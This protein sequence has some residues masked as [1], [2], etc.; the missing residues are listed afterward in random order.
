MDDLVI[1]HHNGINVLRDDLLLG[2]SKTRYLEHIL[3]KN[4]KGY[5]YATNVYGGFQIALSG[6]GL[7]NKKPVHIFCSHRAKTH[8]NTKVCYD[9]K[10][11]VHELKNKHGK[12]SGIY[13]S[14]VTQKAEQFAEQ[15]GLQLVNFGGNYPAVI[16]NIAFTMR[17]IITKL[18]KEPDQIWCAVGSGTLL[19]G[20]LKGTKKANVFGVVVGKS[21]EM[22]HERLTLLPY[23]KPFS[24]ESRFPV[25]F[26]ST[27]NYDAKAFEYC[28]NFGTGDKFFWNVY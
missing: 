6:Y 5:V 3:N 1:S 21:F 17:R 28:L 23:P 11:N 15:N 9:L 22:Q 19:K 16:E 4:A 8:E 10:A 2:G 26:K 27:K 7:Q 25:P 24:Y 18:G 13:F 20:I 12:G 14:Y